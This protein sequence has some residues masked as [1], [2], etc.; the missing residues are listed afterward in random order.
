MLYHVHEYSCR[1][2]T[3]VACISTRVVLFGREH[4]TRLTFQRLLFHL[5]RFSFRHQ[6]EELSA[7]YVKL[8]N[9]KMK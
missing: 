6:C 5:L 9:I 8:R 3:A 7:V 4:N 2:C 1:T